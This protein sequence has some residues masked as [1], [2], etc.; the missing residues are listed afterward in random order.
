MKKMLFVCVLILGCS[1]TFS[2]KNNQSNEINNYELFFVR[3][4]EKAD[5]GTK[6]P[7]LT[8]EGEKRASNLAEI[9]K[10]KGITKIYSTDYKRTRFTGKPLAD[11]LNLEIELYNPSDKEFAAKLKNELESGSALIVGHSNTTPT[12]VNAVLG[13]KKYDQLSEDDYENLF[14]IHKKGD[15]LEAE[16]VKY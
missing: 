5:D 1:I 14:S 16:V 13:E 3:H 4:A 8:S 7:P 11:L 15:Q 9:L 2:C 6:D 12:L 10:D